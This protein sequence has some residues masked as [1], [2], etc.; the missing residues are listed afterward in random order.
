MSGT[1]PRN[2]NAANPE[3]PHSPWATIGN[4]TRLI[5]AA[6][7]CTRKMHA[8]RTAHST[9]TRT[10][11]QERPNPSQRWTTSG[12]IQVAPDAASGVEADAS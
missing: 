9:P 1:A 4:S 12:E 6:R 5:E 10:D 3:Q 7:T 11:A 2:I 8:S